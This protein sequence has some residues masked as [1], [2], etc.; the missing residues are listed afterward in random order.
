MAIGGGIGFGFIGGV[1][2]FLIGLILGLVFSFPKTMFICRK[3]G[4]KYK[5]VISGDINN[6]NEYDRLINIIFK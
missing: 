1:Y 2:V 6:T 5:T 4:T 3:D